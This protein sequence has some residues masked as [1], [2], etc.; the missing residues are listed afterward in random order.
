MTTNHSDQPRRSW[1][2]PR[3][4]A[5]VVLGM[6]IVALWQAF[7][8]REPTG[9]SV[10]GPRFFPMVVALGLVLWGVAFFVRT[11]SLAPDEGLAAQAA[12]EE[13][14][15]HWATVLTI[16]AVLV[17][18]VFALGPLGYTVATTLFF[19]I[20]ARTLGSRNL[21]R[22]LLTGILLGL[23]IYIAFTRFLGVRLPA[24][25]LGGIL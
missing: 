9:Y 21:W 20:V 16:I 4:A 18:Y 14:A 11:T 13:A 17:I 2:G 12:A 1:L 6:G 19:P 5:L 22:D 3:L 7:V 8:I 23:L 24:G 25:V 10:V 15:T